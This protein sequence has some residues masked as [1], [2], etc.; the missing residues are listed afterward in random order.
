MSVMYSP[1]VLDY[2]DGELRRNPEMDS[3]HHLN[4]GLMRYSSAPS[5]FLAS[6]V[7]NSHG[8]MNEEAS[9]SIDHHHNLSS[10]SEMEAMLAKLVSSSSSS[11]NNGW[12]KQEETGDSVSEGHNGYIS[13][14]G[15]QMIYQSQQTHQ[16]VQGLPNGSLG[17][18]GNSFD[19]SFNSTESKMIRP[20]NLLRQK[21]SPAGLFNNFS[22]EN[23]FATWR[24][25]GSFRGCDHVSNGQAPTSASVLDE[26]NTLTFSS[27]PSSCSR[28]LPDIAE[29]AN[30]TLEEE[31]CVD[32]RRNLRND[33]NGNNNNN[34]EC[35]IP[36]ITSD[37]WDGTS[38]N[39]TKTAS[40]NDELMFTTTSNGFETQTADFGYQNVGLT[41]HLS[42][43]SS[44]TKSKMS[45]I[46]KF[47]QV[48][49]S[50]PCKIRAKRGFATHPR[51]IAERVRRTRISERIKKLQDLF[52]KSEKQTS[53][54]DMLDLAVDYIR[55]L[56]KQVQ[57]LTDTKA[58][59]KCSS[60]QKQN[61]VTCS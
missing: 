34:T 58:K 8:C 61:S 44:C 25:V 50:V 37:F 45:A 31:T 55:D 36:S 5:S 28:Q 27:R 51:S 7:Q 38:F 46:E 12:I 53:T 30:E 42:L 6:L 39:D 3:I 60:N 11:S 2:S 23:D 59:C 43:P 19:G 18:S 4:S 10:S 13:N 14:Y 16:A 56:Q 49:E 41:H 1:S 47:L 21:S 29:D 24:D 35:Y 32:T 17:S 52:P 15:S 40:D 22:V 54:A 9:R 26:K 57:M 20:N 48:Q 33:N